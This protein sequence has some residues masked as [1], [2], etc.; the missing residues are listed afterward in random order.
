MDGGLEDTEEDWE[1]VDDYNKVELASEFINEHELTAVILESHEEVDRRG[2]EA[3]ECGEP[4]CT[5]GNCTQHA[6]SAHYTVSD[7]CQSAVSVD[8]V[9]HVSACI[10]ILNADADTHCTTT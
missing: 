5:F 2:E 6:Y 8:M 3:T 10:L 1:S 4:P 7:Y 9:I